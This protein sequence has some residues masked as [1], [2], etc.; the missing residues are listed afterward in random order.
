MMNIQQLKKQ[1][2]EQAEYSNKLKPSELL[3][4]IEYD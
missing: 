4:E 1:F 3:V 2:E